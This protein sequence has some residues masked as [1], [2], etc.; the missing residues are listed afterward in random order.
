VIEVRG[1]GYATA[2][3]SAYIAPFWV[4]PPASACLQARLLVSRSRNGLSTR[5]LAAEHDLN[6]IPAEAAATF[7]SGRMAW[8]GN[9]LQWGGR[10][11]LARAHSH[12]LHRVRWH[13]N[14]PDG[15]TC[16]GRAVVGERIETH[17]LKYVNFAE[18]S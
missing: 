18:A 17:D 7:G 2:H 4:P 11:G 12:N 1:L 13:G 6:G 9:S 8:S 3:N 5:S 15:A 14:D 16:L 10:N